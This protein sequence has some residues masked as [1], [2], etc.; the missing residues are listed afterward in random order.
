MRTWIRQFYVGNPV[1]FQSPLPVDD[2]IRR[3]LERTRRSIFSSLFR[4]A[5]V[6]RV[7]KDSV[8][9]QRVIPFFGNSFKPIFVGRFSTNES[10]TVL[11]GHFTIFLFSK[12][13]MTIWFGFAILWT[14]GATISALSQFLSHTTDPGVEPLL[15]LFPLGGVAFILLCAGFLRFCWYL[16]R[17][18]IGY[19]TEVIEDALQSA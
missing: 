10:G 12:I 11:E 1:A 8:R 18:D 7:A 19:L 9:L 2:C 15:A 17:G 3:L 5:A 4:Q 6:G 14:V 16:S 13:V